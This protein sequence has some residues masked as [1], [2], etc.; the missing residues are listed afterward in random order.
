VLKCCCR[1]HLASTN[2]AVMPE[3]PQVGLL[4]FGPPVA[5]NPFLIVQ[6]V[7]HGN[8][9][10]IWELGGPTLNDSIQFNSPNGLT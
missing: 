7:R 6:F 4:P 5:N 3:C 8:L 10:G 9:D 2:C 1:D